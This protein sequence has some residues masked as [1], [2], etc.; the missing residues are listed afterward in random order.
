MVDFSQVRSGCAC[1]AIVGGRI[2]VGRL[3]DA[4]DGLLT[5]DG[6]PVFH[7]A[8]RRVMLDQG[9]RGVRVAPVGALVVSDAAL[10]RRGDVVV[11]RRYVRARDENRLLSV[12][13][14]RVKVTSRGYVGLW[15]G[16]LMGGVSFTPDGDDLFLFAYRR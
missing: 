8:D 1:A 9:V 4:G 10:I 12:S 15:F 6:V 3:A 16:V 2:L 5:V 13:V 11:W 14:K 7:A